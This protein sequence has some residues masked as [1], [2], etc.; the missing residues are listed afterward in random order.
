MSKGAIGDDPRPGDDSSGWVRLSLQVPRHLAAIFR[1][2]AP[3]RGDVK[4]FGACAVAAYL[5]LDKD[6]RR[7]LGRWAAQEA[8]DGTAQNIT[9]EGARQILVASL[10]DGASGQWFMDRILD[11]QAGKRA[12]D[13][14][15]KPHSDD[16]PQ[17]MERDR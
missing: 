17:N 4:V 7:L 13:D 5:A 6:Q 16:E 8:F 10:K 15:G 3:T 1:A 11:Q 14:P 9:P 12:S 2:E